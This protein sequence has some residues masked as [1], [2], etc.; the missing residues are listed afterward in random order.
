MERVEVNLATGETTIVQLT[1]AEIDA[2]LENQPQIYTCPAQTITLPFLPAGHSL[3]EKVLPG[4]VFTKTTVEQAR[5]DKLEAIRA[6]RQMLF[7]HSDLVA[8][9]AASIVADDHKILQ[10]NL[11]WKHQLRSPFMQNAEADLT[12]LTTIDDVLAYQPNFAPE[13]FKASYATLTHRQF[14]KAAR[15]AGLIDYATA[16]AFS[17]VKTIPTQIETILLT[18]PATDAEEARETLRTMR[19]IP[20]NDLLLSVLFSAAFSMTEQQLDSFF[21]TAFEL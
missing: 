2:V 1:Q 15:Q 20:R 9:E 13:A 6:D 7:D 4:R 18:L 10:P 3:R 14:S 12:A 19:I 21:L 5:L 17:T 16:E 11:Q 8:M